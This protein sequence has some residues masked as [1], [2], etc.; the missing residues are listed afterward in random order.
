MGNFAGKV[1][2]IT[3]ASSGIG[4]AVALQ[5]AAPQVR[6]IITARR[7][8]EL[9]RVAEMCREKGATCIS[10]IADLARPESI[11][12]LVAAVSGFTP[13]LDVLINNAGIS[14]RSK[15]EET[16]IQVDR[17]IMEINFFGQV[18]ITKLLWPLLIKSE[19]A[20]IVLISSV[21]GTFGFSQRSAYAA[22]KHALEGFFESWMIEN[23]RPNIYF[24]TVSPG[25]VKTSISY[26]AL[27]ADGSAHRQLDAG[28]ANG[29]AATVCAEKIISAI[30]RNQRK[31]Y[32]VQKEMVL[33]VLRKCLPFLFFRIAKKLQSV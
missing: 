11:A 22:S 32:I 30:Y 10:L 12:E 9:N 27:K 4:K 20:N 7:I 13:V 16:S 23:N 3:G 17:Q 25:R 2:L 8:D 28:Q 14:Q 21:T 31:V 29:I 18:A 24:T 5:I 6:L 26:S 33:V 1:I 19:H 15:A